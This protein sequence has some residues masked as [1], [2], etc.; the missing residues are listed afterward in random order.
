MTY[1]L[2]GFAIALAVGLTGIGGGSFTVPALLLIAG[3]PPAEAVG[4]TFVF[5]GVL[6][7]IAAPF[8]LATRQVNS[9]YFRLLLLGAIPGLVLG[10]LVLRALSAQ[11][12]NPL[13]VLV[14]GVILTLTASITFIRRAQ[15]PSFARKNSGWLPWLAF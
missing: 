15:M 11:D 2:L 10:M 6:R 13:I 5:A 4:T 8:Y 14:V 3:L 12:S 7:L 9:K 1:V